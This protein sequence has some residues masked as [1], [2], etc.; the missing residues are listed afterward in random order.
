MEDE[1]AAAAAETA[2]V[3]AEEEESA[4]ARLVVREDCGHVHALCVGSVC[5]T[6]R[7]VGAKLS[8]HLLNPESAANAGGG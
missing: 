2:R 1:A 7:E 5:G 8:I 4:A 3:A 6:L